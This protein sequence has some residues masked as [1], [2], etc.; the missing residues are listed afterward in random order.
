ME[1]KHVETY[2]PPCRR[3]LVNGVELTKSAVLRA[4]GTDRKEVRNEHSNISYRCVYAHQPCPVPPVATEPFLCGQNPLKKPTVSDGSKA[5]NYRADL[6]PFKPC[7]GR[8]DAQ[9]KYL[10]MTGTA[11]AAVLAGLMLFNSAELAAVMSVCLPVPFFYL[12]KAP[13]PH[14]KKSKD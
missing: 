1:A 4:A 3:L 14:G 9:K 5:E 7:S 8:P 13:Q 10:V 2:L 11:A 6:H 12:V